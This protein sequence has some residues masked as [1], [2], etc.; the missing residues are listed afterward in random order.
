MAEEK[1]FMEER[2]RRVAISYY[3]RPDVQKAIADF[4]E[5]REAVPRYFE[6]FGKRPDIIQY[7]SDVL[8]MAREGATSFHCSEELWSDPLK[9][10]TNIPEKELGELREGFDLLIDIDSKYL[11]FS[12]VAAELLI[13]ALKFHNVKNIGVKFSGSKGFHIIVPWRAFPKE[14]FNTET[15][16]MFPEWARIITKYLHEFIKKKLIDKISEITIIN[17]KGYVKDIEAA[18]KVS[19]DIILVSS[20]HLFR[21]PYS[22]NEKTALA[23]IVIEPEKL[24]KFTPLDANPLKVSVK[25]FMPNAKENEAKELL[26]QA[27]DW[28]RTQK[29]EPTK[30]NKTAYEEIKIDRSRITYPMS[31]QQM[32][33]GMGDGKKRALFVLINF[34]NYLG[35]SKEETEKKLSEWNGKNKPQLKEGYIKSQVEWTFRHGKRLPPNFDNDGYYKGIGI[36]VSAEELKYKN[37]V[38]YVMQRQKKEKNGNTNRKD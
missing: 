24:N 20:R 35:F 26:T 22:L 4:C 1:D 38:N 8:Q 29:N 34:F 2:I 30:E 14:V 13:G 17:S 3:S 31:I 7:P 16:K 18:E 21:T 37:P 33:N 9:L 27:L 36:N 15:R 32:L 5:K 28:G 11:D 6:M 19:P 25:D 10:S 12:K 23:S